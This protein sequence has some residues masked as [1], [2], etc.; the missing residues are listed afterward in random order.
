MSIGKKSLFSLLSTFYL[1]TCQPAC[2]LSGRQRDSPAAFLHRCFLAFSRKAGLNGKMRGLAVWTPPFLA[3]A[4]TEP[5]FG[6]EAMGA[7]SMDTAPPCQLHIP[8]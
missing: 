7:S 5:T 2:H 4:L 3:Y 1:D 6:K 8:L